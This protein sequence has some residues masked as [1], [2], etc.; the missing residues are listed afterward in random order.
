MKRPLEC[1]D[2][3][4]REATD[5]TTEG[6]PAQYEKEEYSLFLDLMVLN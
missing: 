4:R 2:G 5:P 3:N 6:D 1:T